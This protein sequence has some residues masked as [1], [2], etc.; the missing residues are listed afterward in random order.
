MNERRLVMNTRFAELRAPWSSGLR[1]LYPDAPAMT[2]EEIRRI[3][4]EMSIARGS[5]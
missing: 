5:A 3:Q 1:L 2:F 4:L